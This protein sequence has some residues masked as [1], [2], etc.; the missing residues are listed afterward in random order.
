MNERLVVETVVEHPGFVHEEDEEPHD[1][2]EYDGEKEFPYCPYCNAFAGREVVLNNGAIL[3]YTQE[4]RTGNR[5][6]PGNDLEVGTFEYLVVPGIT[7]PYAKTFLA[8]DVCLDN[9]VIHAFERLLME[10]NSLLL[11]E[12]YSDFFAEVENTVED[13]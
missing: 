12:L 1:C 10:R 2:P 9:V 6:E 11:P 3:R 8:G 4:T 7:R 13:R 5:P